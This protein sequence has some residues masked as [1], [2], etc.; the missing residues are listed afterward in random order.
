MAVSSSIDHD[1]MLSHRFFSMSSGSDGHG[2]FP[3]PDVDGDAPNRLPANG[4]DGRRGDAAAGSASRA[5]SRKQE[6]IW[7]TA[8]SRV[9][10][11]EWH[12]GGVGKTT[13]RRHAGGGRPRHHHE[14]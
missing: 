13:E 7:S 14:H 1:S 11:R 3:L 8:L 5:G 10:R 2:L 9:A 4:S 12:T 6:S